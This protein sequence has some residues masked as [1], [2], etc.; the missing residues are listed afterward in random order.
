MMTCSFPP[1]ACVGALVPSVLEGHLRGVHR[2][3]INIE[4]RDAAGPFLV[5]I[6]RD[7]ADWTEYAVLLPNAAWERLRDALPPA[8]ALISLTAGFES[9]R[10]RPQSAALPLSPADLPSPSGEILS[11]IEQVVRNLAGTE[12]PFGEGNAQAGGARDGS[13]RGDGGGA[14]L[15]V[16]EDGGFLPLILPG[17]ADIETLSDPFLR[18]AA[19]VLRAVNETASPCLDLSPLVGLGV[20]F[21]PSGDDF[22]S[23]ALLTDI[24]LSTVL[25]RKRSSDCTPGTE[26]DRDDGRVPTTGAPHLNADTIRRSLAKTT[27]GGATLLRLALGGTPPAY[28]LGILEALVRGQPDRVVSIARAHG[29]SSGLDTLTGVIW[30]ARHVADRADRAD[31]ARN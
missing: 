19:A 1:E 7:I 3:V 25:S 28:Q 24:F 16:V 9:R 30:M 27:S 26:D 14:G 15:P 23:G 10:R 22:I 13:A 6:I 17:A 20:G 5:S 18:R 31:R 12:V 4:L 11:V 8:G 21:T 29:H 2:T